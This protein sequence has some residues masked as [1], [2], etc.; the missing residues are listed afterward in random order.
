MAEHQELYRRAGYYDIVFD[1]DVACEVDFISTMCERH[2]GR[3]PATVAD[4]ACG[5]A[6]HAREF[7]RRGARAYGMDLRPE[8][9]DLA[10]QRAAASS[11][12]VHTFAA[13]MRAFRLP[14][15]VDAAFTLFDGIDC[16]LTN[17]ELVMH[18]RAVAANL[19]PHG[20]YIVELT[21][22][23]DCSPIA[24]C[25]FHYEGERDGCS[26]IIDWATNHPIPDPLTQIADVDVV[27]RVR[28]PDGSEH[29]F[30]DR[31]RERMI[32][33]QEFAALAELSGVM[34]VVNWYGD[35][36]VDQPFDNT[37][38]ARRMIAVLE[39]TEDT[40]PNRTSSFVSPKLR[41]GVSPKSGNGL[42]AQE[43]VATGEV[44]VVWAGTVMR[45]EE[46]S[47]LDV[48][49]RGLALQIED[50]LHILS[51]PEPADFVNH[52]CNPNAGL[53]GQI[54]LVALRP[55]GVGEEVCYDYAMSEG[56]SDQA[57]DFECR[58]GAADCRGRVTGND[59]LRSDLQARYA[60]FFSPY[61]QRRL[62][63]SLS[64]AVTRSGVAG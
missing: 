33:P 4:V 26:V 11:V 54:A 3:A 1:R 10:S 38:E 35:F 34:R 44:L 63:R 48:V 37:P 32:G 58:C 22:P 7:A 39:R 46:L 50:N 8:M 18:L 9:L 19:R 12:A 25:A 51:Q 42:F 55:I 53:S 20:V 64:T 13:D 45:T 36:R 57:A 2:L 41:V 61:L 5:P 59:W 62:A 17:A 16:L 30:H 24:Y 29:E 52:S 27:M 60:D 31:A 6:Y 15:R 49:R 21:H 14:E 56:S 28:E 43:P 40:Q 23:R 47:N